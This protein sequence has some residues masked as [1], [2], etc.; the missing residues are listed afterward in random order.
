MVC[1]LALEVKLDVLFVGRNL[2][3]AICSYFDMD[4]A[5]AGRLPSVCVLGS[6]GAAGA[7]PGAGS[8][9]DGSCA[10]RDT[11]AARQRVRRSWQLLNTGAERW[12]A[13]CVWQWSGGDAALAVTAVPRR[14][15]VHQLEP[16]QAAHVHVE[17]TAPAEPG[18]YRARWRMCTSAGAYFGEPAHLELH[19]LP[20]GVADAAD[21]EGALLIAQ[22]LQQL[23]EL[24]SSRPQPP[25]PHHNPFHQQVFRTQ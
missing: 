5:A 13:G 23:T 3:A 6:G 2:Q 24:G 14:Q 18:T 25:A 8:A 22:R 19:V 1:A 12:P 21:E 15:P 16:G 4:A 7:A 11:C 10:G 20:A 9:G 17:M